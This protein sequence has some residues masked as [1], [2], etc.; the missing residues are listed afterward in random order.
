MNTPYY[1]IKQYRELCSRDPL[2]WHIPIKMANIL[3][4]LMQQNGIVLVILKLGL[5]LLCSIFYQLF[6]PEFPENY[7]FLN[8]TLSFL[9]FLS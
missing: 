1:G 5:S 8:S 3:Q 7:P 9:L 4:H 6:F 2:K